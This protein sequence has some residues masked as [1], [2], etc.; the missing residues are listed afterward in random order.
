[1]PL[2]KKST[3]YFF[4]NSLAAAFLRSSLSWHFWHHNTT[5]PP[6]HSSPYRTPP[7]RDATRAR[8]ARRP[9]SRGGVKPSPLR[10]LLPRSRSCSLNSRS[11]RGGAREFLPQ[12]RGGSVSVAELSKICGGVCLLLNCRVFVIRWLQLAFLGGAAAAELGLTGR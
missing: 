12:I 7:P 1:M 10:Y 6:H 2:K 9:N 5:P 11:V 3:V 8:A 4:S